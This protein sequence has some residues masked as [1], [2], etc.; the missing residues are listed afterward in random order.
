NNI[1]AAELNAIA[2]PLANVQ[3][4]R[5]NL[6]K[7]DF[8]VRG[9]DYEAYSDVH[10]LY[11]NLSLTFKKTDKET[12]ETTTKKFLTKLVN[13][14]VLWSANP[15]PGGNERIMHNKRVAR[16][17]T[18]AFFGLLWKSI[19]AGMQDIMMKAGRYD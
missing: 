6:E 14:F 17:T 16:L 13:R 3:L 7:L 10:M 15:E 2:V 9:S 12:G 19:F 8:L 18:E 1:S 4:N 11:N 5:F